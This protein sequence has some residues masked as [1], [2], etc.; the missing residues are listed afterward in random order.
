MQEAK[1]IF[2]TGLRKTVIRRVFQGLFL[3]IIEEKVVMVN[4]KIAT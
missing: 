3:A 2:S 1:L 4:K